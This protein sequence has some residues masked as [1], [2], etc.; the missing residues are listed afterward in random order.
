MKIEKKYRVSTEGY[1]ITEVNC[2]IDDDGK[3]IAVADLG[4]NNF[5]APRENEHLFDTED[6]AR[7][8]LAAVIPTDEEIKKVLGFLYNAPEKKIKEHDETIKTVISEKSYFYRTIYGKVY[9]HVCDHF[10]DYLSDSFVIRLKLLVR[11]RILN[12]DGISV[13]I[14]NVSH[15]KWGEEG[16]GNEACKLILKD[17]TEVFCSE[18][19]GHDLWFVKLVFGSNESGRQFTNLHR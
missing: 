9:E 15:V 11:Q 13:S 8:S 7:Q 2:L 5:Y 4:E 10:M 1:N 12:I 16:E 18:K 14:D 6:A 3:V 17:G 19:E